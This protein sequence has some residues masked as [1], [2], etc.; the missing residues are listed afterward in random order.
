MRERTNNREK[1]L[2]FARLALDFYIGDV[3]GFGS[4]TVAGSAPAGDTNT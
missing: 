1:V 4:N 2:A 3:Q